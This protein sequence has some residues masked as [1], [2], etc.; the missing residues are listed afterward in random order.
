MPVVVDASVTISWY[1]ADEA[2]ATTQ[3][4]LGILAEVEGIVPAL[5]WFEIRNALLMNERRGR[6][7]ATQIAAILAHLAKLPIVL[8]RDPTGDAV[9]A[10]ARRYRLTFYDAAYLE[11]AL[12]RDAPLATLDRRLAAAARAAAVRLLA[13]EV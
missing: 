2:A 3:T 6:L 1:L 7:D 9:F 12:R 5:W 4:V 10:L 13:E 8:D 11:L